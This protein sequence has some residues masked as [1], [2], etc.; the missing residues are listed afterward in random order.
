MR[1]V[2]RYTSAA[3]ASFLSDLIR[4]AGQLDAIWEP[5]GVT[6]KRGFQT[7]GNLFAHAA[8]T[9]PWPGCSRT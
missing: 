8:P 9:P 3:D 2:D 5:R 4:E 6:T 7:G 1:I